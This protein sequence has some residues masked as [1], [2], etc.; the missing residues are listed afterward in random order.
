MK[1]HDVFRFQKSRVR[2]CEGHLEIALYAKQPPIFKN[3]LR[4][5]QQCVFMFGGG[6]VFSKTE[7]S[8]RGQMAAEGKPRFS[9]VCNIPISRERLE[10]NKV[11]KM[12]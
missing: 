8:G 5:G 2:A 9:A 12:G 1:P 10:E 3:H 7:N 11:L 6:G 4:K